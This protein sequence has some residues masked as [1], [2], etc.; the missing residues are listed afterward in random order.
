MVEEPGG[1]LAGGRE[2]S[3]NEIV[4][5]GRRG[6]G[7]V[8]GMAGE[9]E[10]TGDDQTLMECK[11]Y[12]VDSPTHLELSCQWIFSDPLTLSCLILFATSL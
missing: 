4:G 1:V 5:K 12:I 3:R 6:P 2:Q 7:W 10:R 11:D 8:S 9:A